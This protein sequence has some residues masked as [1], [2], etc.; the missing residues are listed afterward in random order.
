M[1]IQ[2][3]STRSFVTFS[4]HFCKRQTVLPILT[5]AAVFFSAVSTI[6]VANA[7]EKSKKW[8]TGKILV[9]TVPGLSDEKFS[10]ILSL[11]G[12]GGKSVG[13]IQR[14]G[15]HVLSVTPQTELAM[16]EA[17]SQ[18]PNIEFAELDR[19]VPL[20]ATSPS[21][22]GY[23]RQWHLPKINSPIAWD[24]NTGAGI[25]V[26]IIDTGINPNH[27]D[28]SVLLVTGYNTIENNT[29]TTDQHGHGTSVAGTVAATANNDIGIAAV[30]W[31][32]N[33]MPIRVSD[34]SDGMALISDLVEGLIWAAD[35][36]A[37]IANISYGIS[38]SNALSDAAAYMK[39]KGGLVFSSA[40]NS[41][42]DLGYGDDPHIITVSATEQNDVI[43]SW[44]SFG[45]SVD[46]TAPGLAIY[47]TN[48]NGSYSASSGTSFSSPVVAGVAAL[49]MSTNPA[50]S[51]NEVEFI[52]ESTAKDLG[53]AGWD[54]K[55]GHGR[56]DAGAAVLAASDGQQS[57]TDPS[58]PIEDTLAPSITMNLLN[59][60]IIIATQMVS[61]TAEDQN[62]I[63]QVELFIDGSP[64]AVDTNAPYNF[65]WDSTLETNSNAVV[66]TAIATDTAGNSAST[67]S[68]VTV[69]NIE[70]LA[71]TEA[72]TINILSPSINSIVSRTV[73]IA[74]SSSD[75]VGVSLLSCYIDG[76][77]LA[78]TNDATE[79]S[80][81]WNTRREAT[82][83]HTIM[84]KAEDA[85][86]NVSTVEHEVIVQSSGGG[87]RR[88]R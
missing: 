51:P 74:I 6:N 17:L 55:Y 79:M 22:P 49:V 15:V 10:R 69:S 35:N 54:K 33:L 72:P 65:S 11:S 1:K 23:A 83:S 16:V 32:S 28:L 48:N 20:S 43:T 85:A 86:G 40:G 46:I 68:T 3:F 47:T 66:V 27:A 44:S 41:G 5:I 80:C 77:L 26:A 81:G 39:S 71:D 9:K 29:N 53:L 78:I 52:L 34:R 21:D 88:R 75:N 37:K 50:L 45:N 25:T 36:G 67:S 84:A 12:R 7:K 4:K 87:K 73:K 19:W 64:F 2:R 14:T 38:G 76:N 42:S 58:P 59:G 82:G 57:P 18:D 13:R 70:A 61:V 63:T 62:G 24:I 8:A 30:T 31:N 60:A 56:V